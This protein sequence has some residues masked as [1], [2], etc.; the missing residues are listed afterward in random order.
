MRSISR[1]LRELTDDYNEACSALDEWKDTTKKGGKKRSGLMEALAKYAKAYFEAL[2]YTSL[3]ISPEMGG[4][5][6]Y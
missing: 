6:Y 2:Q 3:Y 5:Y 4:Y 1:R